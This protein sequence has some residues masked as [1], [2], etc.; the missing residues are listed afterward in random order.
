MKRFPVFKLSIASVILLSFALLI[1]PVFTLF[2]W[3]VA[4]VIVLLSAMFEKDSLELI[5]KQPEIKY[6]DVLHDQG[7]QKYFD[8]P[9]LAITDPPKFPKLEKP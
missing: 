8:N 5:P 9:I 2:L 6:I 4:I 7:S 3:T 1:G